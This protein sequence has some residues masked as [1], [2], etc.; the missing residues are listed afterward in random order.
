MKILDCSSISY[1]LF[2]TLFTYKVL[3][4]YIFIAYNE[5]THVF[6]GPQ[7]AWD[8]KCQTKKMGYPLE[9]QVDKVSD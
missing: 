9:S 5:I 4:K 1:K 6:A 3:L 7:S 8:K 2:K